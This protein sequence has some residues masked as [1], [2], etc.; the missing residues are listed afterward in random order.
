[1]SDVDC[2]P[3]RIPSTEPT[4]SQAEKELR[5]W[6]SQR[7]GAIQRQEFAD[8]RWIDPHIARLEE[9][10]AAGSYRDGDEDDDE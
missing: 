9:L 1:M 5:D 6:T 4:R 7:A 8:L 2:R 3:V 10:I